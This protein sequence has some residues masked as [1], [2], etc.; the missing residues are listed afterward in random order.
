MMTA[1]ERAAMRSRHWQRSIGDYCS[2]CGVH[3]PCDAIRALDMLDA[4]DAHIVVRARDIVQ[5]FK[6][7]PE[8]RARG[9][10]SVVFFVTGKTAQT[11]IRASDDDYDN[12]AFAA[13]AC[14]VIAA[15]GRAVEAEALERA[16]QSFTGDGF[17][18]T[19]VV[20]TRLLALTP[21]EE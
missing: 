18:P 10:E 20:R 15:Y 19:G 2:V 14:G 3:W 9:G 4:A 21:K 6:P 1:E 16:A 5:F 7:Y 13:Q 17:V 11:V 12:A 8:M